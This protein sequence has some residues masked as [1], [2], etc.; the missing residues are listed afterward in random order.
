ML[1]TQN[2]TGAFELD[3]EESRNWFVFCESH[4]AALTEVLDSSS[5]TFKRLLCTL[6]AKCQDFRT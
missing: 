1:D 4:I 3:Q 5:E 2:E 6:Q